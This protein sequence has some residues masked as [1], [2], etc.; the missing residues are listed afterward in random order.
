MSSPEQR[1]ETARRPL[2]LG[3]RLS[4]CDATLFVVGP[5]LIVSLPYYLTATSLAQRD[6]QII[7]SKLG[8]YAAVYSRGGIRALADTVRAEQLTAP[9][10][11]FVRVV[12][13]GT[14]P[15]LLS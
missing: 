13:R 12:D 11:L 15:M 4:L 10:R 7:E 3:L 8:A 14:E 6:R 5:I 9:E 2:F 1:V